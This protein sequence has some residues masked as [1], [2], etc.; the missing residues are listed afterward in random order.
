[1]IATQ[2]SEV[3]VS[4]RERVEL[5]GGESTGSATSRRDAGAGEEALAVASA[6]GNRAFS[7][8]VAPAGAQTISRDIMD[9]ALDIALGVAAGPFG[10]LMK[11]TVKALTD[12]L[13][14]APPGGHK[15]STGITD[16]HG[17]WGFVI[18][19][20]TSGS[21]VARGIASQAPFSQ[22]KQELNASIAPGRYT[23]AVKLNLGTPSGTQSANEVSWRF[24]VAPDGKVLIEAD[25]L[26]TIAPSLGN[27]VMLTALNP[28]T[29]VATDHSGFTINPQVAGPSGSSSATVGG[30]VSAEPGGIGVAGSG[31]GTVGINTPNVTFQRG[32]RV[33]VETTAAQASR[34]VTHF[35]IAKS[36]MV[37][38]ELERLRGW[39][40]ALDGG[41]RKQVE[42]GTIDVFVT[43]YA[44]TTGKLKSNQ[45]LAK[46]R[47]SE[48]TKFV[49]QFATSKAKIVE[50]AEGEL[51]QR[52][53]KG[54]DD[55][56]REEFR[57][58]DVAIGTR[59]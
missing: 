54:E 51:A 33:N 1:M 49:S 36:E 5:A 7:R 28:G 24:R 3:S 22:L 55:T 25:A 58:T 17:S 35:K 52:E 53:Q 37:E 11:P 29:N 13:R 18:T 42:E 56:E 14:P 50:G 48:T 43:G 44:S 57:R 6:V 38:G 39:Y 12:Q 15:G 32:L 23:I 27:D 20:A 30:E 21:E 10:P 59:F 34:H 46:D 19:D 40:K 31:S 26:Q 2:P 16:V 4:L 8:A 41:L 47:A 45:Q 9:D